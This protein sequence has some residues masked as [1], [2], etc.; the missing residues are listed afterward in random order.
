MKQTDF[1]ERN[2]VGDVLKAPRYDLSRFSLDRENYSIMDDNSMAFPPSPRVS[3]AIQRLELNRYPNLTSEA[4]R[5]KIAEY[6]SVKPDNVLIG[7]GSNELIDVLARTFVERGDEA[8][9]LAPSYTPY[10]TRVA[11]YGGKPVLVDRKGDFEWD[12]ES[13][14][15]SIS[16]K[17]KLIL[18]C[19]PNNPTGTVF[20][21]EFLQAILD[22]GKLVLLD[23]AYAEFSPKGIMRSYADLLEQGNVIVMRTLSKAFALAGIRLGYIVAN[24]KVIEFLFAVKAPLSVNLIAQTAAVAA[25]SDIGHMQKNVKEIGR[26]RDWLINELQQIDGLSPYPSEANFVLIKI[27]T[28]RINSTK[29]MQILREKYRILVRD[30]KDFYGLDD[31]YFRITVGRMEQNEKCMT[32][33]REIMAA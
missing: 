5:R 2:V 17:T 30:M 4:A 29:I 3:E 14:K 22:E 21:E 28:T 25:L 10:V 19:N 12:L 33:V 27:L 1:V 18:L 32:A 15:R 6:L 16:S 31:T 26:N 23:E 7:N 20:G 11:L 13:V 8:V 9:I 24:P